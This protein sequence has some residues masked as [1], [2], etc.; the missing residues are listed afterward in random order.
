MSWLSWLA[1]H[2]LVVMSWGKTSPEIEMS[3]D[4]TWPCHRHHLH[5][6]RGYQWHPG[7]SWAFWLFGCASFDTLCY[8]CAP[9]LQHL[10][11]CNLTWLMIACILFDAR[12]WLLVRDEVTAQDV[13]CRMCASGVTASGVAGRQ[14]NGTSRRLPRRRFHL[15]QCLASWL[16]SHKCQ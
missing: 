8:L 16:H 5:A 12:E 15:T 3:R 13:A 14:D 6:S 10:L 2:D 4:T 9:W 7:A 11:A 1:C